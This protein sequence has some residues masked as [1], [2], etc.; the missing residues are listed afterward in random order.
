MSNTPTIAN[1]TITPI[2]NSLG[3]HSQWL[4][5]PNEG[6]VMHDKM[7]DEEVTDPMTLE[8]TGEVVLGFYAGSSSVRYDYDFTAN[9]REF[10]AVLRT[11]VPGGSNIFNI[12]PEH[13]VM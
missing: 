13:E 8:P 10:Y 6:Y 4:I 1:L 12:E 3:N 2:Y 11:E 7:L 9:P 5:T